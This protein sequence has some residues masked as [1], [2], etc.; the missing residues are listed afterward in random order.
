MP[1][2]MIGPYTFLMQLRLVRRITEKICFFIK[3]FNI[4][5]LMNITFTYEG[6]TFN[7]VEKEA[8][9]CIILFHY[10]TQVIL[11]TEFC[12]CVSMLLIPS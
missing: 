10:V 12:W 11:Y 5:T 3:Y 7:S 4:T 1:T 9:L 6:Q 2:L 8:V